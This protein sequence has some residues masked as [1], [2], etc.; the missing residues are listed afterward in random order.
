MVGNS[1][2]LLFSF[3]DCTTRMNSIDTTHKPESQT[4]STELGWLSGEHQFVRLAGL[5][6]SVSLDSPFH[7]TTPRGIG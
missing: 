2:L 5:R 6:C 7:K 1:Y 3:R 4:R